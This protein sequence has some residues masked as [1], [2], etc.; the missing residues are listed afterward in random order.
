MKLIYYLLFA[1][2]FANSQ[3]V[4]LDA[5]IFQPFFYAPPYH[6]VHQQTYGFNYGV[7]KHRGYFL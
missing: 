4:F 7:N 1:S 2:I 6:P 5:L 3:G